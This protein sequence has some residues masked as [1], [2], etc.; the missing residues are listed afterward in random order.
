MEMRMRRTER[1]LFS[2]MLV[3]C[4]ISSPPPSPLQIIQRSN[5]QVQDVLSKH[6]TLDK[7]TEGEIFRII[8]EVT[9]FNSISRSVIDRFCRNLTDIQCETFDRVFQRLLM[10][11]SI[12]KL[13]RYRAER[14]EYLGEELK[15]DKATVKTLA[16]YKDE[17]VRLDYLLER[18]DG[19]WLVFNY[20]VD[21]VDTI[22]NYRKQFTRLFARTDFQG[23]VERLERK[24]AEYEKEYES[25]ED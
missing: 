16:Y 1:G 9:D 24:T 19:K 10:V 7:E 20:I 17:V 13:G 23:I 18:V 14:F 8:S 5:A 3:F 2:V 6:V 11:S 4:A 22:H 21:D 12:K 15:D 25:L